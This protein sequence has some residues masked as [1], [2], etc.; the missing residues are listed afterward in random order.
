MLICFAPIVGASY[1]QR[2]EGVVGIP[3]II[4]RPFYGAQHSSVPITQR[5][6]FNGVFVCAFI[7]FKH[8]SIVLFTKLVEAEVLSIYING[9]WSICAV[10]RV[11]ATTHK[12]SLTSFFVWKSQILITSIAKIKI[13]VLISIWSS[14]ND[15]F[16]HSVFTQYTVG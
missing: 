12:F 13:R 10:I 6:N 5:Q 2:I 9:C 11:G 15:H 1:V 4:S 7:F 16:I 14:W 3:E 8:F